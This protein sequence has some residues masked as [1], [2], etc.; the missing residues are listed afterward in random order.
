MVDPISVWQAAVSTVLRMIDWIHQR[1]RSWGSQMRYIWIGKDGWP[2]RTTLA[3]MIE[4][5]AL[6]AA[7]GR[8]VQHHPECLGPEELQINNAIKRLDEKDREILFVVY[9]VR[10]KGKLTMGRYSLSRTAY[11]DWIDEVH[12]RVSSSLNSISE[13][14]SQKCR[15]IPTPDFDRFSVA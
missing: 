8:F 1:C 6:G 9:V 3:R 15:Q 5:G 10:E 13:Q 2:S 12:K 14:N 11:Y 7:T 4:E